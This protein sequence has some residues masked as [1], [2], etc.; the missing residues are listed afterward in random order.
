M[1]KKLVSMIVPVFNGEKYIK[2]FY[3]MI[4]KQTNQNFELIFIDDGSKDKSLSRLL[5]LKNERIFVY[6]QENK[7][8][9]AARNFGLEVAKGEYVLFPDIDDQLSTSYVEVFL[10]KL[11]QTDSTLCFSG[12]SEKD[13]SGKVL[14]DFVPS[15]DKNMQKK[16]FFK[17]MLTQGNICSALWNKAFCMSIIKEHHLKFDENIFIGEDLLFIS[18]YLKYVTNISVVNRKLYEYIKN[19]S[20]AMNSSARASAFNEKWFSEWYALEK[21]E[22][23][24]EL[25]DE[26]ALPVFK[27]KKVKVATKLVYFSRVFNYNINELI[28]IK[29]KKIIRGGLLSYLLK[30]ND[31]IRGK[32]RILKKNLR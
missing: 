31:P 4:V 12:Y 19:P 24:K 28:Y 5:K 13:S 20:S 9:S 29:L 6:H 8:V 14:C 23:I 25:K 30:S 7:G 1:K 2:N 21:V 17:G 15:E 27:Y 32:L 10:N 16:I 26:T 18:N 3:K 11:M 22:K